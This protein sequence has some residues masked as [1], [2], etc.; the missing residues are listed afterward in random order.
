METATVTGIT[1]E[2]AWEV[3]HQIE[4]QV[5]QVVIGQDDLIRK[6]L[7]GLFGRGARTA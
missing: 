7:I 4:E 2:Q 3:I 5:R 6:V 1:H